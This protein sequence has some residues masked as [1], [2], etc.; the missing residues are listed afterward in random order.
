MLPNGYLALALAAAVGW[1]DEA[2][3]DAGLRPLFSRR[4]SKVAI[5]S[6]EE[7]TAKK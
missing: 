1:G 5:K 2:P 6:I 3:T 7:C 4:W